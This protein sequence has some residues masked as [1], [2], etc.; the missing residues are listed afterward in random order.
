MEAA[1]PHGPSL[2]WSAHEVVERN[3]FGDEILRLRIA[4]DG[5]VGRHL[6]HCKT[7]LRIVGDDYL[8]LTAKPLQTEADAQALLERVRALS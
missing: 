8:P 3:K 4:E 7:H 1:A 6:R 2:E 5:T